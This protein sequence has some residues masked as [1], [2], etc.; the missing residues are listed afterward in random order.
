MADSPELL[1]TARERLTRRETAEACGVSE[2][3]LARWEAG[4]ADFPRFAELTLRKLLSGVRSINRPRLHF[5]RPL[6]RY[7]RD[8]NGVRAHP[9]RC[10][11]TSEWDRWAQKTYRANFPTTSCP[12]T[13]SPAT[14]PKST[15]QMFPITM[16]YGWVSL[17]AVLHRRGLKEELP[18]RSHGFAD[19]TQ[20][21]LFFDVARI[22][23]QKR[24]AAFLLENVKNLKSHDRGRT[25]EVIRRTLEDD[26]GYELHVRVVNG[27][28]FT[29][30]NRER[31]VLVGFREPSD[32]DF[33]DLILEDFPMRVSDIL[34]AP[35]DGATIR[36]PTGS[37]ISRPG[38]PTTSTR[39][40]TICGRTFKTTPPST[41]P[42]ATASDS[43]SWISM[44]RPGRFQRGTTRMDPR[45]SSPRRTN[46]RRLTLVNVRA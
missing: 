32:F 36:T 13:F 1:R 4:E 40:A 21:T 34:H 41:K 14:S 10:V 22:I 12:I 8:P 20:G 31:I 28:Y 44:G 16:C 25:F 5:R 6:R 43:A 42:Q 27:K 39:S 9:G 19:L 18:R 38:V 2:R 7:R 30:Q 33:D 17:P 29:P 37:S 35:E 11:F 26:L 3:T 45:S 24:P 15:Q 23:D 46:P